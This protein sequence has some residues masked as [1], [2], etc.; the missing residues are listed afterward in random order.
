MMFF[1]AFGRKHIDTH[2]IYRFS[3]ILYKGAHT[4][5]HTQSIIVMQEVHYIYILA[6]TEL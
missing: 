6:Q 3:Y 1:Y 2:K 5:T 4:H